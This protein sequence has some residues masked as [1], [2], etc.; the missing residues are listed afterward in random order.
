MTR[1][2]LVTTTDRAVVVF[3]NTC[4]TILPT[5]VL[6]AINSTLDRPARP[7]GGPAATPADSGAPAS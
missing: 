3:T 7:S 4:A 6:G 5:L 1:I 2:E